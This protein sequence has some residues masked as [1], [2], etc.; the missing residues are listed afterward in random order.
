MNKLVLRYL[1]YFGVFVCFVQIIECQQIQNLFV[2][3]GLSADFSPLGEYAPL[4]L[5]MLLID[6]T[7]RIGIKQTEIQNKQLELQKHQIDVEEYQLYRNLYRVIGDI[8]TMPN[9][10]L[11]SIYSYLESDFFHKYLQGFWDDEEKKL[12]KLHKE[13][14]ECVVDLDL[15]L[16][17]QHV[18]PKIYLVKL[19][20]CE[21][22]I[23]EMK[24]L[25]TSSLL[26][27][28]IESDEE[29]F[30]MS[31]N[32]RIEVIIKCIPGERRERFKKELNNLLAPIKD[33]E[34]IDTIENKYRIK[35]DK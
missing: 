8:K 1:I 5:S 14:D 10:L 4:F 20:A 22:V 27:Y 7:Y 18:I 13:Y 3:I 11:Y 24:E 29:Y 15:I 32:D 33:Q 21:G 30:K 25:A 2:K 19:Y 23:S 26:S 28:N 34:F 12:F 17:K 6:V 16:G 31:D 9:H 35:K